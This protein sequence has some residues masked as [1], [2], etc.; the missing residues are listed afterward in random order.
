MNLCH[1]QQSIL[2]PLAITRYN[3]WH[4]TTF[5]LHQLRLLYLLFTLKDPA[6]RLEILKHMKKYSFVSNYHHLGKVIELLKEQSLVVETVRGGRKVF[7]IGTGGLS[8]LMVLEKNIRRLRTDR[9][10]TFSYR[11]CMGTSTV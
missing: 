10:R 5:H 7:R 8:L 11:G 2:L 9:F 4:H 1:I 3:R 6:N